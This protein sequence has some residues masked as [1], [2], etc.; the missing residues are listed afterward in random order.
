MGGHGGSSGYKKASSSGSG[1][2]TESNKATL[3]AYSDAL[4][5]GNITNSEYKLLMGTMAKDLGIST[6]D[7]VAMKN[8]T[9]GDGQA[10]KKKPDPA[11]VLKTVQQAQANYNASKDLPGNG[12][13]PWPP[14]ASNKHM[15]WSNSKDIWDQMGGGYNNGG[16]GGQQAKDM[17]SAVKDFTDGLYG[18]IRKAQASGDTTSSAGQKA[19]QLESF[20]SHGVKAGHEWS[21]GTTYR[22]IHLS[23]KIFDQIRDTPIGQ[24]VDPNIGGVASW[25]TKRSKSESFA[26]G[27][28]SGHSVVFVTT[29][30]THKNAVSIKNLSYY[31]SENEVLASGNNSY[32]KVGQFEKDGY[33]YV[34][35]DVN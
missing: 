30:S 13:N 11:E 19:K 10:E 27:G 33:L 31:S 16:V 4:K 14:D 17:Y 28:H 6:K 7:L 29:G 1:I 9:Y 8:G 5:Q 23:S 32:T 24:A 12:S 18:S 22:G 20:I 15:S 34:Y 3:Q 35:V 21:G 26:G 25:S 2:L